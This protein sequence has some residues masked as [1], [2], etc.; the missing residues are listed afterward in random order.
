V[1]GDNFYG[2]CKRQTMQVLVKYSCVALQFIKTGVSNRRNIQ[3][4]HPTYPGLLMIVQGL[5]N[6]NKVL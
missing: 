2:G 3:I 6:I 5:S 4:H 1:D